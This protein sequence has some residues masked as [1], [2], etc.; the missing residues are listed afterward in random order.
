MPIE[1]NQVRTVRQ[2]NAMSRCP[3]CDRMNELA[4]EQ[5]KK[6]GKRRDVAASVLIILPRMV[7]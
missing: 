7:K 4:D 3:L 5:A 6:N 2:E 1:D